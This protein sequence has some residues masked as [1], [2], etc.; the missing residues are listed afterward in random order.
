MAADGI[1]TVLSSFGPRETADRLE[2]EI[3]TRGDALGG[4]DRRK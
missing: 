1:L 3:T 4:F 2:G